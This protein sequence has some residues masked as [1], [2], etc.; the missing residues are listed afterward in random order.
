MFLSITSSAESFIVPCFFLVFLLP[1]IVSSEWLFRYGSYQYFQYFPP[2]SRFWVFYFFSISNNNVHHLFPGICDSSGD[3]AHCFQL[4]IR[5]KIFRIFR[6]FEKHPKPKATSLI[7]PTKHLLTEIRS[8]KKQFMV[9]RFVKTLSGSKC[10]LWP[11]KKWHS[12]K[13][14]NLSYLSHE[15]KSTSLVV[16]KIT[17]YIR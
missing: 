12:R 9:K 14:Q 8:L 2:F 1:N 3:L 15:E 7:Y 17:L 10:N 13:Q 5:K 4:D 16:L 11:L 6:I